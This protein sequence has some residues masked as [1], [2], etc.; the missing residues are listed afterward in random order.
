MRALRRALLLTAIASAACGTLIGGSVEA[1]PTDDP[2]KV[3]DGGNADG[4]E[5]GSLSDARALD[6]RSEAA[7]T[8]PP[9]LHPI[10]FISGTRVSGLIGGLGAA[11]QI[12][13]AEASSAG[14]GGP[15]VAWLS[16]KS[17]V[18]ALSRVTKNGPF[19][20]VDRRE[21]FDGPNQL[22]KV[23]ITIQADGGAVTMSTTIGP[24]TATYEDGRGHGYDDCSG[25][26]S[27]SGMGIE[28]ILGATDAGWTNGR[29]ELCTELNHII[30]FEQ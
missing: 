14:L 23:P 19:Y 13:T 26:T 2:K 15:Y 9:L 20:L 3:A 25:W 12:C 4:R 1:T 21:V 18:D 11:D 6:A 22:P 16:T 29:N 27:T 8:G 28:G 17:A 5:G 30:C 10:V 7:D 24:W